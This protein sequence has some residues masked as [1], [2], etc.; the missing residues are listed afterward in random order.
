[1]ITVVYKGRAR[2]E[3]PGVA[4]QKTALG[5]ES[6][7]RGSLR[8]RERSSSEGNVAVLG[9][10][11]FRVDLSFHHVGVDVHVHPRVLAQLEQGADVALGQSQVPAPER[12]RS[13]QGGVTER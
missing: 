5:A 6:Q 11:H 10:D 12:Q 13:A 8:C 7:G 4:R 9:E 2:C 1:M 3:G